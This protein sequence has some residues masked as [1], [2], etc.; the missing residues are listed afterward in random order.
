[1]CT[2]D[3]PIILAEID[4]LP[5]SIAEKQFW[6]FSRGLVEKPYKNSNEYQYCACIL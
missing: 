5:V 3:D 2:F 4:F 1:M 6:Y